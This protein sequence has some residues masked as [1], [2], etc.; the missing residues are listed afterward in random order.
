MKKIKHVISIISL[1]LISYSIMG[2][3]MWNWNPQNWDSHTRGM[4]IFT[5]ISVSLLYPLFY[6]MLRE[7]G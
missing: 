7:N 3:I 6:N 4:L 5:W 1:G 2:F